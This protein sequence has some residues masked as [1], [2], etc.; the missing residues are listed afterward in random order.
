MTIAQK[1]KNLLRP[2]VIITK[3]D[4]FPLDIL[5]PMIIVV[6]ADDQVYWVSQKKSVLFFFFNFHCHAEHKWIKHLVRQTD[7]LDIGR[8]AG[9]LLTISSLFIFSLPLSFAL[10][11]II[12]SCAR[13]SL[14]AN[15]GGPKLA[16][17]G[18]YLASA[19]S[20]PN[21]QLGWRLLGRNIF[22]TK[23]T[24]LFG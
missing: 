12:F 14:A 13:A 7:G 1:S 18:A 4:E 19:S 11:C 9:R 23:L 2:K 22:A 16:G 15:P 21:F 10:R 24:W 3:F 20:G 6:T 8:K 17:Q 5:C